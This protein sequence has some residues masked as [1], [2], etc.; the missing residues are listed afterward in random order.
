M[1]SNAEKIMIFV[2]DIQYYVPMKLCKTA[3]SIH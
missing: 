3:E 1:F 2:S